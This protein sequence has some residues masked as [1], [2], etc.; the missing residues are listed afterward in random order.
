MSDCRSRGH[1]LEPEL[2]HITLMEVDHRIISM[3]ILSLLLIYEGQLS[4]TG[5]SMCT[6]TG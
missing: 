6:I 4:I 2:G 3:V 1:E 5:E